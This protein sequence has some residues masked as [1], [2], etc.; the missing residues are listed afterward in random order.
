MRAGFADHSVH[1]S[2]VLHVS[3]HRL[4]FLCI[5]K[6]WPLWYY[7]PPHTCTCYFN[8]NGGKSHKVWFISFLTIIKKSLGDGQPWDCRFLSALEAFL[9]LDAIHCDISDHK[10]GSELMGFYLLIWRLQMCLQHSNRDT[11]QTEERAC[12]T[13]FRPWGLRYTTVSLSFWEWALPLCF[14]FSSAVTHLLTGTTVHV[15]LS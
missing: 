11:S 8:S 12:Q 6:K 9:T 1:L 14:V 5:R 10:Q 7:L 3:L 4:F 13:P 2:C 15:I